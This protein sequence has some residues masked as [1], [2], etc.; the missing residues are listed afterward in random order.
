MNPWQKAICNSVKGKPK[1][2]FLKKTESIFNNNGSSK[3]LEKT[4]IEKEIDDEVIEGES[5]Q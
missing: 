1:N 4:E 3:D 2:D 5:K